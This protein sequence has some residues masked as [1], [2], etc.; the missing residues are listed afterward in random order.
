[1]MKA[2]ES[3][4]HLAR[5]LPLVGRF[6]QKERRDVHMGEPG[7]GPKLFRP[8]KLEGV[9]L[10]VTGRCN[11][12]CRTCFYAQ[13][14]KR[15]EDLSFHEIQRLSETAPNFDKLWLSGGEP[16]LREELVDIISLFYENNGVKSI[17]LPTN[18]L[19]PG[20]ILEEVSRLLERC[21]KL[22]VHLNF[23][24]DGLPETHDAVRGVPGGFFKTLEALD[25]AE[26]KFRGHPR[27]HR[28]VATV[29]NQETAGDAVDLAAFLFSRYTLATHFF[30]VMR[31]TPRDPEMRAP[32]R[33]ELERLHARLLPFSEAM[34]TRL[35]D[36]FPPGVK[37]LAKLSFVGVIGF[38]FRIQEE[39]VDG[40][41][42][43]PMACTAGKTTFVIDHDGSFRSCE[44]RPPIGKVQDYGCD[45]SAALRSTAMRDEIEAIGG[46]HRAN[47]FC[48]HTCWMLS[49]LKFSPKALVYEIPKRYLEYRLGGRNVD[50]GRNMDGGQRRTAGKPL[51]E[52][53]AAHLDDLRRRHPEL[54]LPLGEN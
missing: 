3:L 20:R 36:K 27:V 39:N 16:F 2:T 7:F 26:E 34:A 18:G 40:P 43:W 1:M 47:C 21:P 9:F 46:G 19:L 6:F 42:P 44:M 28:N 13:D 35:F 4:G 22:T 23:S 51:A 49:S 53:I 10:F 52:Q 41:H 38:L 33:G 15:G 17:N 50:G 29:L 45:L 11:S 31:G 24:L 32:S 14:A 25:A 30:E 8:K 12:N 48:T 5:G 37:E 54:P